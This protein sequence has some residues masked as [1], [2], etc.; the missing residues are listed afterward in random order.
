MPWKSNSRHQRETRVS[1]RAERGRTIAGLEGFSASSLLRLPV[2]LR[3]IALGRAVD[4]I[5][6]AE[7]FRALGLDIRCNDDEHRFLPLSAA[8]VDADE[9][10]VSSALTLLAEN[11]LAFYRARARTM[12]ELRGAV[13]TSSR[14][15]IGRL[16]DA[17]LSNDG[18]LVELVLA[19]G[20]HVA[21]DERLAISADPRR[22]DAA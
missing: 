13:V 8:A 2:R 21:V 22:V 7:G 18:A 20:R 3:G 6:D 14:R 15:A 19:D 17:I 9:I 11:E 4:V 5:V 12:R 1:A 10:A 16:E